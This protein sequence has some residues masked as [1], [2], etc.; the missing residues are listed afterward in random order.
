MSPGIAS[1]FIPVPKLAEEELGLC[2]EG[3][4]LEKTLVREV[5][6]SYL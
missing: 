5:N 1:A 2:K 4:N 6:S 3:K